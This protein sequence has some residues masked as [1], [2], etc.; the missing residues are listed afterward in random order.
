MAPK[1]Q[2]SSTRNGSATRGL[3]NAPRP[4]KKCKAYS[5]IKMIGL[6]VR[7]S[8]VQGSFQHNFTV[9]TV[10]E[11]NKS[12]F[13]FTGFPQFF[14]TKQSAVACVFLTLWIQVKY[15]L[16]IFCKK[17]FEHCDSFFL[18][19]VTVFLWESLT[20]LRKL[21]LHFLFPTFF[22]CCSQTIRS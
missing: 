12:L 7:T 15:Q 4:M 16:H 9:C 18:L 17:S 2:L 21:R 22:L 1:T 20:F 3:T 8:L 19:T 11:V 6:R 13:S 10:P 14:Q 5:D